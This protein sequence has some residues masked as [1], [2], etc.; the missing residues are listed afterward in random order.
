MLKSPL[1]KEPDGFFVKCDLIVRT[2]NAQSNDVRL[3][4]LL[5][6]R[7]VTLFKKKFVFV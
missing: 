1:Y 5:K 2:N 4:V 7:F 6:W 3:T